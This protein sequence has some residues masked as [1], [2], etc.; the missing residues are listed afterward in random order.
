VV[1]NIRAYSLLV[2]ACPI[3]HKAAAVP[4]VP[5]SSAGTSIGRKRWLHESGYRR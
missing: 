1:E 4:D 5:R 2:E 3:R